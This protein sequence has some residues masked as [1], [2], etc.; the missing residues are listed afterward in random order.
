[1]RGRRTLDRRTWCRPFHLRRIA[2]S[3]NAYS[4]NPCGAA[5]PNR[6]DIFEAYLAFSPSSYGPMCLDPPYK[7]VVPNHRRL[8]LLRS[9]LSFGWRKTIVV[10]GFVALGGALPITTSFAQSSRS[11]FCREYARDYSMRY[12]RGGAMGG[13]VR[14]ALGGAVI[15]GIVD[16]GRGAS[17]GAGAGAIVGGASRGIQRSTLFDRAYDRCMRR[18]WP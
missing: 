15:G 3:L 7:S 13:V 18:R 16:G 17:R 8:K 11:Q 10:I 5:L 1:D 2:R 14:G 6:L 9:A 12:S 4:R